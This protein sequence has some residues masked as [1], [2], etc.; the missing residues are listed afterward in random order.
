ML[1]CKTISLDEAGYLISL[2]RK[3]LVCL[4]LTSYNL[5]IVV[6]GNQLAPITEHNMLLNMSDSALTW[7]QLGWDF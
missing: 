7:N 1:L 2:I 3:K 4:I 5:S 6:D